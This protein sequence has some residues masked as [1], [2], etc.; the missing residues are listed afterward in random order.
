MT[1][2]DLIARCKKYD[3]PTYGAKAVLKKRLADYYETLKDKPEEEV[4]EATVAPTIAPPFVKPVV[5]DT[6]RKFTFTGD[7]RVDLD[8]NDIQ[9][10]M[11]DPN[12]IKMHGYVF[13]L[14]AY[15]VAVNDEVA[16]KLA[17]HNHF[18]EE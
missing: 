12:S 7:P 17:N 18:T 11:N 1:N 16:E 8:E 13:P 5:K 9:K 15:S 2:K 4:V 14:R 10:D 3:L 6:K